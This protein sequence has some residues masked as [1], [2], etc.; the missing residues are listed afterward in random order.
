MTVGQHWTPKVRFYSNVTGINLVALLF[1]A[2]ALSPLFLHHAAATNFSRQYLPVAQTKPAVN[3]ISGIPTR[4]TIPSLYIDLPVDPGQYDSA[5]NTW[6][7]HDLRA[8][9]AIYSAPA[10]NYSGNTFIYGH[11]NYQTLGAIKSITPG[12]EAMLYT[13]NGHIFDYSFDSYT[14][15]Q[16]DDLS[17]LSYQGKP[18]LTVQTCTGVWNETRGMFKFNLL[19]VEK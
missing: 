6:T 7:L 9:Y 12:T 14:F 10:N 15:V 8:Y 2:Y 19:K 18:I 13:S 4:I 3:I 16:P 17:V 5:T 11:N 1:L